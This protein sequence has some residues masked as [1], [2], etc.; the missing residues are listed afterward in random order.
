MYVN[1]GAL[2][3][4]FEGLPAHRLWRPLPKKKIINNNNNNNNNNNDMT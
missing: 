2:G 1:T 3:E 4:V